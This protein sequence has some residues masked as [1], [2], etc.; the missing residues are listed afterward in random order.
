MK[1]SIAILALLGLIENG[2]AIRFFDMPTEQN[3]EESHHFQSMAQQDKEILGE[4]EHKIDQAQ[5]NVAQGELGRTLAMNKVNEIKLSLT[6]FKE[7]FKEQVDH[8]ISDP[9]AEEGEDAAAP[10]SVD[11]KK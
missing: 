4:M 9:K 3:A 8:A 5:R 6:Q 7:H 2:Q 10:I 11:K 1:Y